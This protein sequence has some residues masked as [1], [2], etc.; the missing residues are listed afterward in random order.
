MGLS[1]GHLACK[2]AAD[3]SVEGHCDRACMGCKEIVRIRIVPLPCEVLQITT[4][5]LRF[6]RGG[7]SLV[8]DDP[9][10]GGGFTVHTDLCWYQDEPPFL[11]QLP[12][13][14]NGPPLNSVR[15][16]LEGR[17]FRLHGVD[18]LVQIGLHLVE[19]NIQ[20]HLEVLLEVG[21][22]LLD[23]SNLL[24]IINIGDLDKQLV[25]FLLS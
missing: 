11:L 3:T 15:F 24:V 6:H 8:G 12:G 18:P 22:I 16:L 13:L 1:A 5:A 10:G 4:L 20:G 25:A 19:R 14:R 21:Q 9:N 23:V 2:K 7:W 17:Q